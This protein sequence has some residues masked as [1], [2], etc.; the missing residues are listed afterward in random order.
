MRKIAQEVGITAPNMY[1]YVENKEQ[2]FEKLGD[3]AYHRITKLFQIHVDSRMSL[4]Q[5]E[6]QL[7][8][9]YVNLTR[10]D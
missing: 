5:V 10:Q 1:R 4:E 7:I 3:A 2:L 9:M 8:H 6:H